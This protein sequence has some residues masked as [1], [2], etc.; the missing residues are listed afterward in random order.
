MVSVDYRL[1]PETKL[2]AILEDVRDAYRWVR[3]KGPGLFH[4]DPGRIAIS[5]GS[6]GGYL[7]LASGFM[8]DPPPKALVAFSLNRWLARCI[9][10]LYPV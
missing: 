8:D 5:G 9:F 3:E 7:T 4:A 2:P 1:A 6:A 10:E